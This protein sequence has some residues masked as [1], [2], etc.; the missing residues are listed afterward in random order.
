MRTWPSDVRRKSILRDVTR[1]EMRRVEIPPI[2]L[3]RIIGRST[4]RKSARP[5]RR[6]WQTIDRFD[7]INGKLPYGAPEFPDDQKSEIAQ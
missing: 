7:R 5:K 3:G 6:R 4:R 1:G 2:S